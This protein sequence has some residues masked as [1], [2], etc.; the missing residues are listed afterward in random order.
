MNLLEKT[1]LVG[2]THYPCCT[3]SIRLLAYVL[4]EGPI[5]K[6]IATTAPVYMTTIRNE[7]VPTVHLFSPSLVTHRLQY[8][9]YCMFVG[10][11]TMEF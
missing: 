8:E 3:T 11:L 2:K 5:K 9:Q 10:K 7:A 1:N 6:V 4:E